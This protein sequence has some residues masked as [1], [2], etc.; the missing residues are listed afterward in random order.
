MRALGAE[1]GTST[2]LGG[3]ASH[4]N[5]GLG[6]SR[7]M[8]TLSLNS[9]AVWVLA[10]GCYTAGNTLC[11]D[12]TARSC[13]A[14]ENDHHRTDLLQLCTYRHACSCW[15]LAFIQMVAASLSQA[16]YRQAGGWKLRLLDTKEAASIY[17]SITSVSRTVICT[18]L[19]PGISSLDLPRGQT[20]SL[21]GPLTLQKGF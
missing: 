13:E 5:M 18:S 2:R 21:N 20:L 3:N 14:K 1:R 7:A 11:L 9:L 17:L 15:H 16:C 6:N 19:L 12:T 8:T 10:C 4:W